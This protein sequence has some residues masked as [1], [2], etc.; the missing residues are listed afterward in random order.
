MSLS[1]QLRQN[2]GDKALTA[3]GLGRQEV[4][5]VSRASLSRNLAA[6]ANKELGRSWSMM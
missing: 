6:N 5:K 3:V 2:V 4:E 1:E